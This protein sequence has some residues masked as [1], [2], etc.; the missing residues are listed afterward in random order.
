VTLLV[1]LT[2]ARLLARRGR[3]APPILATRRS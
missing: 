2:V 3:H 1:R